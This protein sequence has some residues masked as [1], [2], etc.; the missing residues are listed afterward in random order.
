M[1]TKSRPANIYLKAQW[2]NNPVNV[3]VAIKTV[4]TYDKYFVLT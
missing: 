1:K 4:Y 3:T 2:Q